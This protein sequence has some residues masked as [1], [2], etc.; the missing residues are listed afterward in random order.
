MAAHVFFS[1][2]RR[3]TENKC[4]VVTFHLVAVSVLVNNFL[5]VVVFVVLREKKTVETKMLHLH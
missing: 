4:K 5:D 2:T 1:E 3:Q